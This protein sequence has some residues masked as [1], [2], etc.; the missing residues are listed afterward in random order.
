MTPPTLRPYQREAVD[1]A[2]QWHA[3]NT[4]HCL[5]VV[6]TGGG[7][8]LILGTLAHEAVEVGARVLILA[9][10]GEL[11]AQNA[12][13]VM[14]V[15]D[16]SRV[17]VV[18]GSEKR[19]RDITVATIQ[20]FGRKPY[21]YGAF[22]LVLVDEAH[23]IPHG[24]DGLYHKA[25]AALRTMA[26]NMRVIGLTATPYRLTSG[27][28]DAGK[29]ALFTEIAYECDLLELLR[30]GYLCPLRS[31]AGKAAF[32]VAG[33]S[34]RGGDF[35]ASALEQ[36]VDAPE[37]TAAIVAESC[38]LAADRKKWLIFAAGVKHAEH[39]AEAFTAAGIPTAA[40]HGN[41]SST[42]R[43]TRLA[44]FKV[45]EL[46]ALTN[47]DLLTT[48]FDAPDIDCLVIARPT[49]SPG[50]HVQILGRGLRIHPSKTDTI[51]LDFAG[52]CL[53]H[54]P[55]DAIRPP[56]RG[57][58]EKREGAA[59][60]RV[61]SA[62][63][64]ITPVSILVCPGCGAEFPP[65][66][67]AKLFPGATGAPALSI[68]PP[69]A[70][71]QPVTSVEYSR[72]E[73][74]DPNK[75]PTLRVD[76]LYHYRRIAAE[77]LCVEHEG[78]ARRKAEDWWQSRHPDTLLPATI[79]EALAMTNDLATPLEIALFPDGKY[80]RVADARFTKK[81]SLPTACWTCEHWTGMTCSYWNDTPPADVQAR[82]CEAWSDDDPMPF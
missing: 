73:P 71:W 32:N 16:P 24:S 50:L 56:S 54:G 22:D 64:T 80:E 26:P 39:L 82:G 52:N 68:E 72:H 30:D 70:Q 58:G 14:K 31:L 36:R 57:P 45:G 21:A 60:Q 10:R 6:P 19:P 61:C 20:T 49:M 17:G 53:R 12:A 40:V 66:P 63:Q 25:F 65:P 4:G 9:H 78:F 79:D 62:C 81:A 18:S 1:A 13:A 44:A 15:T 75:R 3:T 42:D 8:S 2:V 41:L 48:G 76:Y 69:T 43:A 46:R 34:Q 77:W 38:E 28:L 7:K 47:C 35:L 74:R 23:L 29:G 37:A 51:V 33:V 27:R 5:L 11:I 59:P 55:L 67:P